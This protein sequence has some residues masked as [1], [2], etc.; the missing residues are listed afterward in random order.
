[1]KKSAFFTIIFL[2]SFGAYAETTIF[3]N[4]GPINFNG[5]INSAFFRGDQ[6]WGSV[7]CPNAKYVQVKSDV[8]GRKEIL[9][10][11]LSAKM[12]KKRVQFWGAC[13]TDPNYFNAFYIVVE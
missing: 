7:S 10:I 2:A 6:K 1:M 3:Q 11:A 12:A 8:S 5:S 13:D 9:S 4:I